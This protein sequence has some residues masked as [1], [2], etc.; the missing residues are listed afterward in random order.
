MPNS[1]LH[2]GR[3]LLASLPWLW[4]TCVDSCPWAP[5]KTSRTEEGRP[6]LQHWALTVCPGGPPGHPA[7]VIAKRKHADSVGHRLLQFIPHSNFL[8]CTSSMRP[9]MTSGAAPKNS[10]ESGGKIKTEA[11][12]S[13]ET[14][15]TKRPD[16]KQG[17]VSNTGFYW[18]AQDY[19][20]QFQ[21]PSLPH[22]S[23]R[24]E[25]IHTKKGKH[26]HRFKRSFAPKGVGRGAGGILGAVSALSSPQGRGVCLLL[27]AP[28]T[29]HCGEEGGG[30]PWPACS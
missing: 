19:N 26:A 8:N 10:A 25:L 27:R 23:K 2:T 4:L 24:R 11:A 1:C 30:H 18:L 29:R 3:H 9:P 12:G 15:R 13:R 22:S 14:S 5:G 17:C 28:H 6:F 21:C 16:S 20:L 7:A